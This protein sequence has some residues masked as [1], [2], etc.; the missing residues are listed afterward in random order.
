MAPLVNNEYMRKYKLLNKE[1]S[2]LITVPFHLGNG[3]EIGI[4]FNVGRPLTD[5]E[6]TVQGTQCMIPIPIP[7][8]CSSYSYS[9]Y[10]HVKIEV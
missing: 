9:H 1:R 8:S 4:L 3:L 7:V 5:R 2:L 10:S 6:A